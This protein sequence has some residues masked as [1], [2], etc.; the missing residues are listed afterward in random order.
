MAQ[1]LTPTPGRILVLVAVSAVSAVLVFAF[2]PNMWLSS[3]RLEA[4]SDDFDPGYTVAVVRGGDVVRVLASDPAVLDL[5]DVSPGPEAAP[6]IASIVHLRVVA[7]VGVDEVW[8]ASRD[9]DRE[10]ARELNRFVV[11]AAASV[12][13]EHRRATLERHTEDLEREAR[14]RRFRLEGLASEAPADDDTVAVEVYEARVREAASRLAGVEEDLADCRRRAQAPELPWVV[15]D[16]AAGN[17]HLLPRRVG[18]AAVA[19]AAAP[20]LLV[21]VIFLFVGRMRD[22]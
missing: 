4:A 22:C 14:E 18:P 12:E 21:A 16:E 13:S 20:F 19:A 8:V 17:E 6:E 11:D 7:T 15:V 10:R 1:L 3:V 9:R 5:L 2:T